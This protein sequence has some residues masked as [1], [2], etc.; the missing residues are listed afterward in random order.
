MEGQV[1]VEK[2]K[3]KAVEIVVIVVILAI[4]AGVL[5]YKFHIM[6]Q[7]QNEKALMAEL[8]SLR[9]SVQVYMVMNKAYPPDLK[10]LASQKYTIGN[11]EESYI[12]GVKIGKDGNHIDI[13]GK[14]FKYD[15]KT[16]WLGSSIDKYSAW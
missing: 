10:T 3:R 15:P 9:T 13:F 8:R 11:R 6:N 5:G 4:A 14:S 12:K 2:K 16:G 7:L 1:I